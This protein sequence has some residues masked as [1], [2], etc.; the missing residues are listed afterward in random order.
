MRLAPVRGG[1]GIPDRYAAFRT[2]ALLDHFDGVD[3][4]I[5]H[6]ERRGAIAQ[7]TIMP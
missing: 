2:R 4:P 7:R 1:Q 5:G 3:P 6:V